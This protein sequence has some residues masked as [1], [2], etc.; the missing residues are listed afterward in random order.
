MRPFEQRNRA[1][2]RNRLCVAYL[3][4]GLAR[5]PP[6][7]LGFAIMR[8]APR[9]LADGFDLIDASAKLTG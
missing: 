3:I 5:P 6:E 4:P 1:S 9:S 8:L 7:I 2:E